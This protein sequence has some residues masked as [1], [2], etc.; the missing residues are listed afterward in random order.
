[1]TIAKQICGM[2]AGLNRCFNDF[3]H[4]LLKQVKTNK[5][6]LYNRCNGKFYKNLLSACF[7]ATV[8]FK[9]LGPHQI[10]NFNVP[11]FVGN[12]NYV[13]AIFKI[14]FE[15]N[16]VGTMSFTVGDVV[17]GICD[18]KM[19]RVISPLIINSLKF[20]KQ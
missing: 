13:L 17:D 16:L 18:D 20:I 5:F 3:L 2:E 19:E 9:K 10:P 15:G 4:T 12:K 6:E 8:S 14:K 7:S 1:M 11:P